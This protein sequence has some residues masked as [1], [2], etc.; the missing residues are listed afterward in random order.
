MPLYYFYIVVFVLIVTIFVLISD[1]C[2]HVH[3][4]Q[5]FSYHHVCRAVAYVNIM[6]GQLSGAN[7]SES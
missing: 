3:L 5:S 7:S 1:H 6:F 2:M 4:V